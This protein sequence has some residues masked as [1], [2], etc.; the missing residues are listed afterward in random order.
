MPTLRTNNGR[1]SIPDSVKSVKAVNISNTQIHV[2]SDNLD[3]ICLV[4]PVGG[5]EEEAHLE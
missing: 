5:K 3:L 1:T 2:M 4:Y